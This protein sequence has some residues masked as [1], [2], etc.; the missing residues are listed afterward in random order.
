[1]TVQPGIH[2]MTAEQYH[3]DPA[4]R[5]SLS[6]S[7]AKLLLAKSPKHAWIVHPQLGNQRI[8]EK[9]E[10]FDV[11]TATHAVLL[12]G[13]NVMHEVEAADWRTKLAQEVRTKAR[14]AGLI[15][16][17]THQYNQVLE[18]AASVRE[19]LDSLDVDPPMFTDGKPERTLVWEEPN[20]V[21]CRAR[22]DWLRDDMTAIDDYKST[23]RTANPHEWCR[24]TLW[25]IGADLQV[26]FYLRGLKALAGK[27]AAFR[28][29]IAETT[30]PYALS[31]VSLAPDALAL[32]DDKV[33]RAIELWKRC[34]DTGDWPAYPRQV[35]HAELPPWSEARW[36]ERQA[37]EDMDEVAA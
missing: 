1:M 12:E 24:T 33:D 14:K 9:E 25:N 4:E 10:R 27:T 6:A 30:P 28:Y 3:S 8:E 7:I 17:L 21:L 29:C 31:V 35:C 26:S 19:Q 37:L 2:T 13:R 11:G 15:P 16:L 20:G 5:P 22:L 36:M 23:A 32:A 34:L 18:M